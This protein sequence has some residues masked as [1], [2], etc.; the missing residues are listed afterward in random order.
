[1]LG[2]YALSAGYYDE[3]YGRA[4][5][6]R[7]LIADD[8]R[9]AYGLVKESYDLEG[10]ARSAIAVVDQHRRATPNRRRSLDV[11]FRRGHR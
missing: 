2:T 7:T 11:R 8:F 5:R 6:A 9:R 3:Y 4:L 1:M 10:M